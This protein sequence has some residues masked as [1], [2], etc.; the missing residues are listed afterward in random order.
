MNKIAIACISVLCIVSCK[1]VPCVVKQGPEMLCSLDISTP[2]DVR[3][4][5]GGDA[6][7]TVFDLNIWIYDGG[8]GTLKRQIFKDALAIAGSGN[9][10]FYSD[11]VPGDFVLLI[12]NAGGMV[13]APSSL[14]ASCSI[15]YPSGG[16]LLFMGT[17]GALQTNG[18]AYVAEARLSRV[19]C[20][21]LLPVSTETGCSVE[22][23]KVC[24]TPGVISFVAGGGIAES[25]KSNVPEAGQPL[26]D[27]AG[28]QPGP[29]YLIPD[30]SAPML[31]YAECV[32][33]FAAG[34]SGEG[35]EIRRTRLS[36]AFPAGLKG[37][38]SYECRLS[39]IDEPVAGDESLW[40][41]DALR[42]SAAELFVPVGDGGTAWLLQ[43]KPSADAGRYSFSL[44]ETG[45]LD[46]DGRFAVSP[47]YASDG[48]LVGADVSALSP[49]ESK[50]Y[51]RDG[52]SHSGWICL[53]ASYH[54]GFG[55]A[56]P[57]DEGSD[58]NTYN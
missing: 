22:S 41:R 16:G 31:Q 11:V 47:R 9:V 54:T 35:D 2:E 4:R 17:A 58:V 7:S 18:D 20:R 28:V 10:S 48:T 21:L 57:D 37:G 45:T 36:E 53:K 27:L 32:V 55:L 49:G 40:T 26:L 12:A 6:E 13:T 24:D 52:H 43:E 50:L 14:G 42:F 33:H 34:A 46:N 19:M 44:S 5:S 15:A 56:D 3:T 1:A 51:F 29:F 23:L 8:S 38:S 30:C 25:A 39:A